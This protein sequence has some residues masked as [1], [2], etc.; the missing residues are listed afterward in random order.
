VCSMSIYWHLVQPM[1]RP[2]C[3][4]Y[5]RLRLLLPCYHPNCWVRAAPGPL[6][7]GPH[8]L[9]PGHHHRGVFQR[10]L[11]PAVQVHLPGRPM[12]GRHPTHH[13][14]TRLRLV[15]ASPRMS[16][17]VDGC[18]GMQHASS[19]T[20]A[21]YIEHTFKVRSAMPTCLHSPTP[22]CS[23]DKHMPRHKPHWLPLQQTYMST[24]GLAH[25]LP[26]LK[27]TGYPRQT[28]MAP[29]PPHTHTQT[30]ASHRQPH[31]VFRPST[32]MSLLW[33]RTTPHRV[34]CSWSSP[35]LAVP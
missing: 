5:E 13:H 35:T 31:L 18:G 21:A 34:A 27:L 19:H 20:A 33:R 17:P 4:G 7:P 11:L 10:R 8:L 6:P 24:Q 1:P 14:V 28:H 16:S 25:C 23:R 3:S 30:H 32:V 22:C 15:P 12:D 9:P 26:H 29:P 2:M